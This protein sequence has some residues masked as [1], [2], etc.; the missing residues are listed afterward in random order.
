MP[1]FCKNTIVT[2]ELAVY[3]VVQLSVPLRIQPESEFG[4]Q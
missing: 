4:I 2:A 3:C 1:I